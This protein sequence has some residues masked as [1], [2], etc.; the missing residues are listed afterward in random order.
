LIKHGVHDGVDASLVNKIELADDPGLPCVPESAKQRYHFLEV[1]TYES[2]F[3]LGLAWEDDFV[4]LVPLVFQT[5]TA[6][7]IYCKR[8]LLLFGDSVVLRVG[9]HLATRRPG[10]HVAIRGGGKDFEAPG[11]VEFGLAMLPVQVLLD[12]FDP[13]ELETQAKLVLERISFV[14]GTSKAHNSRFFE[15]MTLP[16]GRR[17]FVFTIRVAPSREGYAMR[18]LFW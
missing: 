8:F 5:L 4:R 12:V 2:G 16:L 1:V 11:A 9:I 3:R 14:E 7:D 17:V 15:F 10:V 6:V 18:F 13:P